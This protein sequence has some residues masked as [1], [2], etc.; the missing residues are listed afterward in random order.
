[1]AVKTRLKIAITGFALKVEA[2]FQI[3]HGRQ[4]YSEWLKLDLPWIGRFLVKAIIGFSNP[5]LK[6]V[7]LFYLKV[8]YAVWS[9]LSAAE[10]DIK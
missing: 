7:Q 5:L 3:C 9:F 2:Y 6:S 10:L 4:K 8:R 1:M